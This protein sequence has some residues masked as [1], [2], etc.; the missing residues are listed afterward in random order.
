[1][2]VPPH[3]L[4]KITSSPCILSPKPQIKTTL[5]YLSTIIPTLEPKIYKFLHP[6]PLPRTPTNSTS[7]TTRRHL[8]TEHAPPGSVECTQYATEILQYAGRRALQVLG[9]AAVL[10]GLHRPAPSLTV[11]EGPGGPLARW[12]RQAT[13]SWQMRNLHPHLSIRF[14]DVHACPRGNPSSKL[15]DLNSPYYYHRAM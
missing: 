12:G 3:D 2:F 13:R 11:W 7:H 6:Q 9:A 15:S 8:Q 5:C 10:P 1:M 14:Q 4:N